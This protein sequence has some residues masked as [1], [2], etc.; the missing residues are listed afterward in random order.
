MSCVLILTPVIVA[1]WPFVAG[2]VGSVLTSLGY[3]AVEGKEKEEVRPEE[4]S[5]NVE[6]SNV[7][8]EGL[9]R[10]EELLFKKGD[11]E[12]AFRKDV[13]GKC[14]VVVRGENVPKQELQRIGKEVSQNI[15][16]RYVYDRVKT[17]LASKGFAIAGE[18]VEENQT[19]RIVA[20]RWKA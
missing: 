16:R 18:E 5:V 1:S 3:A 9:S 14:A 20:T 10:E 15:I 8:M 19:V 6:N 2:V 13:R 4:I 7:V 12:V 17:E 11:V